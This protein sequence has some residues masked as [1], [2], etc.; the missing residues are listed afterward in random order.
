M[1]FPQKAPTNA[2]TR[3]ES[4]TD[5]LERV[6][7]FNIEWVKSGHRTGANYHNVSCTISLKNNEW[8]R[9]GRWMWKN[10]DNYTGI[11]VLPYDGGSYKQPPFEDIDV[12]KFNEMIGHLHSID[13][14]K[15]VETDDNTSLTAEAACAGGACEITFA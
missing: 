9:A 3:N 13:L 7:K 5:L 10:R 4:F 8:Y 2:I 11:S 14:S 6:K 1:S 15:V 12:N